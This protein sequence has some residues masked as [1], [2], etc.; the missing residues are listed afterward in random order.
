MTH[1]PLLIE[2]LCEELP[3]KALVRL[4]EAL[5]SSLHAGLSAAGFIPTDAGDHC[6]FATPRRLAVTF[7]AVRIRQD[8]RELLRKGPAVQAGMDAT[9]RPTPALLGFARSCG[10]EP[11]QLERI[12]EGKAEHFAF[13]SKKPGEP[14]DAHLAELLSEALKK[15]PIPK[16]MRWGAGESQFVR[17]VHGLD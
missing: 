15:L 6:N 13:R 3:P 7:P 1:E 5:G 12:R 16:M 17:P 2:L 10:V 9:G 11:A 14:L 4:S 8:D